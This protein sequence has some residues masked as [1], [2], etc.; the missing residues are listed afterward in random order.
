MC[1]EN[2]PND[3]YFNQFWYYVNTSFAGYFIIN[4]INN[5]KWSIFTLPVQDLSNLMPDDLFNKL[6]SD[7]FINSC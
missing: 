5:L 3:I 1:K 2:D 7:Y 6:M 4:H